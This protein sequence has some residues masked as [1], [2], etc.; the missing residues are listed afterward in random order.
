[1]SSLRRSPTKMRSENLRSIT[2]TTKKIATDN[3]LTKTKMFYRAKNHQINP[4]E[5]NKLN[6]FINI[7]RNNNKF[8]KMSTKHLIR[9]IEGG[10]MMI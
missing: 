2:R 5:R 7:R 3:L 1:M 10:A 6:K 9:K 4:R 8:R